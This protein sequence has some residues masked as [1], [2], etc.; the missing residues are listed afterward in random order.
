[1]SLGSK[2]SV[3]NM[4]P[5]KTKTGP[6]SSSSLRAKLRRVLY[7][8]QNMEKVG[9][10]AVS[11]LVDLAHKL[12]ELA[13]EANW[14]LSSLDL[15]KV[16]RSLRK[17]RRKIESGTSKLAV[18]MNAS[19]DV[20]CSTHAAF[21]FCRISSG[22]E[23]LREIA[24]PHVLANNDSYELN[25]L[26]YIENCPQINLSE[27][28]ATIRRMQ[29][30]HWWWLAIGDK[31]NHQPGRN[32]VIQT[33]LLAKANLQYSAGNYQVAKQLFLK[34]QE[35]CPEDLK[36]MFYVARCQYRLGQLSEV[37]AQCKSI[38]RTGKR[39]KGNV[40]TVA[41]SYVLQGKAQIKV[42][43]SQGAEN[44]QKAVKFLAEIAKVKLSKGRA[45]EC[46]QFCNLI[47]KIGK[48]NDIQYDVMHNI[49]HGVHIKA[50]NEIT[51][52]ETDDL[53]PI[54]KIYLYIVC[55]LQVCKNY[56]NL[57][58]RA[59]EQ[60]IMVFN[61]LTILNDVTTKDAIS[62]Q[63]GNFS[64]EIQQIQ[65]LQQRAKAKINHYQQMQES[66]EGT[67]DEGSP[68]SPIVATVTIIDNTPRR[69]N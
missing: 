10:E 30:V 27:H 65:K 12:Y 32:P 1:M 36:S 6:K 17:L 33:T 56:Y 51:R 9:G 5:A 24:R 66:A 11:E 40:K 34:I 46:I 25:L 4:A 16:K 68:R 60:F 35:K 20:H 62:K 29:K 45:L 57:K 18:S 42:G 31:D 64:K 48:R 22:I 55:S 23:L 43:Q 59:I 53:W 15:D 38:I 21:T 28:R 7:Q 54:G 52:L 47:A 14:D 8:L 3:K 69:S 37:V 67:S 13:Q 19:T 49:F 50:I 41:R 61:L 63:K 44:I 26:T 2:H 58:N 39:I